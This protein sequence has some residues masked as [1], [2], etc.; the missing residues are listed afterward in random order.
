MKRAFLKRV[1]FLFAI[2]ALFALV[3]PLPV[4][5]ESGVA[6]KQ[7]STRLDAATFLRGPAGGATT[8]ATV[9][10]TANMAS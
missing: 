4:S 5:A 3:A 10:T 7:T 2:F 8:C 1:S 9:N 6:V